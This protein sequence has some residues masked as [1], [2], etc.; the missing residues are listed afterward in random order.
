MAGL[1]R[2]RNDGGAYAL[3]ATGDQKTLDLHLPI[4]CRA[5]DPAAWHLVSVEAVHGRDAGPENPFGAGR[6][7]RLNSLLTL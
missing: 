4:M 2:L 5:T 7:E 1:A 3:A 6:V